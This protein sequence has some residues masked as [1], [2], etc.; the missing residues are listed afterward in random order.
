MVVTEIAGME[1]LTES[2]ADDSL[3]SSNPAE[4][5]ARSDT[6]LT[7]S[8]AR[9]VPAIVK[10]YITVAVTKAWLFLIECLQKPGYCLDVSIQS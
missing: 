5:P 10:R 6:T 8:A 7:D 1:T 9:A 4:M 2:D 3:S